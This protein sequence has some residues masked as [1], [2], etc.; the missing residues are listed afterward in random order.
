MNPLPARCDKLQQISNVQ[1]HLPSS[2]IFVGLN[3]FTVIQHNLDSLNTGWSEWL[4][5]ISEVGVGPFACDGQHVDG[6]ENIHLGVSLLMSEMVTNY[7]TSW[8]RIPSAE[9]VFIQLR[10]LKVR[11]CLPCDCTCLLLFIGI[12]GEAK[13][14]RSFPMIR[15]IVSSSQATSLQ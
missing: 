4:Q 13:V 15:A 8:F 14:T 12:L 11:V 7:G 1:E 3:R 5:G 9:Q 10:A 2:M 6:T